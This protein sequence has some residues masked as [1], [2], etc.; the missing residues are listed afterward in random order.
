MK[1]YDIKDIISKL[2]DNIDLE[3]DIH[4]TFD[5]YNIKTSNKEYNISAEIIISRYSKNK[6]QLF[7]LSYSEN[8]EKENIN[9]TKY[10]DSYDKLMDGYYKQKAQI[11]NKLSQIEK[12]ELL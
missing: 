2:D 10:F 12:L 6:K 11:F 7:F 9:K 4:K 8:S 1:I 5:S 3:I